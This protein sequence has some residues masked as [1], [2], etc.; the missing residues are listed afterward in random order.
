MAGVCILTLQLDA[1][2]QAFFNRER[3]KHFPPAINYLDAH[4]TL[5]H[6]LPDEHNTIGKITELK[7]SAFELEITKPMHLG[8]GVAYEINS[9]EIMRLH[10]YLADLFKADL[11]PQDRQKF[12]PHITIQ[13][14]VQPAAARA[15]LS[16]IQHHFVPFTAVATG[17]DLWKYLGGPWQHVQ[18]FPFTG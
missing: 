17:L 7:G 2:S 4:L 8:N 15:L 3:K 18:S 10:Q 12:R 6:Q 16:D 5:F 1:E 11:I 9:D 14:K 13:N